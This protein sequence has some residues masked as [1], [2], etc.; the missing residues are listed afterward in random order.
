MRFS[1]LVRSPH[2]PSPS[3]A[4]RKRGCQYCFS[5]GVAAAINK[6]LPSPAQRGRG[7]GWGLLLLLAATI[8]APVGAK[9]QTPP[10]VP[11][12]RQANPVFWT[13][14]TFNF[15]VYDVPDLARDLNAV[16]V[17]HAMAYEDL[18]TGH[19][20]RLETD[21][22]A[23]IVHVL[24]NPPRLMPSEQSVSPTFA[25]RFGVLEQVF[26]GA[27]LLHAQ[28][29]DVLASPKLTT[30]QKDR[31]I[32]RLY[33]VYQTTVPYAVTGLPMNMAFLYGQKY[34]KAFRDRYPKV[35]GLFWGYHYLQGAMY[36]ALYGKTPTEQKAVYQIVGQQYRDTELYRTHRPLMPMFA[37][38][39]PRFAARFPAIANLFDNLHMLHDRVNDILVTPGLRDAQKNALVSE[40][41]GQ[42]LAVS[43]AGETAGTAKTAGGLHDHRFM[44]GMPGMGLMPGATPS[45]MYMVA[46]GMG[47]MT[48][49]ECHHCSLPLPEGDEAW[50]VST[51]SADGWTM[52]VRCPLCARDMAGETKG[53]AVLHLATEDP[54]HPVVVLSDEQANLTTEQTGAVFLEEE[55]SHAACH[56]WSRAFTSQAA[57]DRY[58]KA[59]PDYKTAKPL[60][61]DEWAN[62]AG[63]KPDT[64]EKAQGPVANPYAHEANRQTEAPL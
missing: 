19:A 45:L 56:G 31:E 57:F 50:Q 35:N 52:R 18:V 5:N 17:G 40:A 38:T 2:P 55:G 42:V 53:R 22:Y 21:T 25:R 51:V 3:P 1:M 63:K 32:E 12:N 54:A 16:S 15:A 39:S 48:M 26:D 41:M 49:R 37:E 60:T 33:R 9:A 14:G 6:R 46:G 24:K 61:F 47:W 13:R 36:D 43:H 4:A 27:H 44:E 58:I 7:R 59:N 29:I 11:D 64:Y 28:T 30:A 20:D 34:S 62:R 10:P 23:R 8:S